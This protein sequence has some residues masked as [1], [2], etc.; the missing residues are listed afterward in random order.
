MPDIEDMIKELENRLDDDAESIIAKERYDF[1]SSIIKEC[2]SKAGRGGLTVSDKIDKIV[3][4]RFLALPIF[5]AVMTIVY[6]FSVSTVGS[7]A[8]DWVNDGLFGD[9]WNFFGMEI[10]GIPAGI[11]SLLN[12]INCAGWLQG[13]VLD[14]VVAGVGGCPR[15]CSPDVGAISFSGIFGELW[16]YGKSCFYYGL[17]FSGNSGFR[18]SH[19]SLC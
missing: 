19:L 8:T 13:L 18:A 5:A 7:W 15:F 4:N 1:I 3:T 9:E 11:E 6:Y 12:A 16:I 2:V 17:G 10:P 14:G